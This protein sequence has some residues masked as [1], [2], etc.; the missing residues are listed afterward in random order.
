MEQFFAANEV[1]ATKQ[2]AVFLSC[3]WSRTYS[4]LRSLLAPMK[5]TEAT[6][7]ASLQTL[8][9]HYFP[10][11]SLMVSRFK[12]NSRVRQEGESISDYAD[13]LKKLSEHCEFGTFLN[14][15]LRDRIVCGINDKYKLVCLKSTIQHWSPWLRTHKL[16]NRKA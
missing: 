16:W 12:F 6:L 10:K 5:P 13:S 15:L 9:S 2:R 8:G 3:C 7:E 14:D 1:P 4:T 11:P